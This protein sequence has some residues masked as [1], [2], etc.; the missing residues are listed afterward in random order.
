VNFVELFGAGGA[1]SRILPN[2][3]PRNVQTRLADAVLSALADSEVLLAEADTGTGKSLAYLLPLLDFAENSDAPAV[4]STYTKNLQEQLLRKDVP[5]ALEALES[6][7]R[8]VLAKGRG[9]YLCIR[10]LRKEAELADSLDSRSAMFLKRITA[11]AETT[12]TGDVDTIGMKVPQD[13]WQTVSSDGLACAGARCDFIAGCFYQRARRS[14]QEATLIV[15]NHALLF[16]DLQM[17]AQDA[18]I[19]PSY[20]AAVLDEAHRLSDAITSAYTQRVSRRYITRLLNRIRSLFSE[21]SVEK[22][23]QGI[24]AEVERLFAD[25]SQKM[26]RL[27]E[28]GRVKK[29]LGVDVSA[30]DE[31]TSSLLKRIGQL[32]SSLLFDVKLEVEAQ[33]AR[34]AEAVGIIRSVVDAENGG[35]VCYIER[36]DDITFCRAP[37][38]VASIFGDTFLSQGVPTVL[39]GATLTAGDYGFNYIMHNLGIKNAKLLRLPPLFDYENSVTLI[40][41]SDIP[42][43]TEESYKDTICRI[44]PELIEESGGGALV[45]F[46]SYE[47]MRYVHSKAASKMRSLGLNLLMQGEEPRTVLIEK[48]RT[49]QKS[50]LFGTESFWQGID[51]PGEALRLLILTKLPFDVPARPEIEAKVERINESGGNPFLDFTLPEA[52]LKLRQGFGRLIRHSEDRGTVAILDSRILNRNYGKVFLSALPACKILV[53]QGEKEG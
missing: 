51:V 34:L 42:E 50:V 19:L 21:P 25:L 32:S 17:R 31:V 23:L 22:L 53:R 8:V 16:T 27:P 29:P 44:I 1:L 7:A 15:T 20:S 11:W 5:V 30:L 48:F 45:L 41:Y 2:F 33:G 10:R 14:W 26:V 47:T 24:T 28:S 40:L 18:G 49:D 6:D 13:V 36:G 52:V 35:W 3:E 37:I 9:N 12:T 46:T 43:P 38:E 39:V 4:V